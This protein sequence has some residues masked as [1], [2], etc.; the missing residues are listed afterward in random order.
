MNRKPSLRSQAEA[1]SL[2]P[3]PVY[4][5]ADVLQS[6]IFEALLSLYQKLVERAEDMIVQQVSGEIESGLRAHFNANPS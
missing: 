6:T 2:L 1:N 3:D 4:G 5:E